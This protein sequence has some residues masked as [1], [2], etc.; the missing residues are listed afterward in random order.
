[1][2]VLCLHGMGS[3]C[4]KAAL[5][6]EL[7]D[8]YS[9]DFVDG[10]VLW[11]KDRDL[12]QYVMGDENT[13]AI[14]DPTKPDSCIQAIENLEQY[15]LTEGPYDGVMGF[16]QGA[17]IALSW[18]IKKQR[19]NK[20][21]KTQ[22]LPFKFGIFFSNP[23]GVYDA[24]ALADGQLVYLDPAAFEGLIDLPTAHIWGTGDKDRAMAQ[25]ISNACVAEK[26]SVFIHDQGHEIPLKKDAVISMAK[27]INRAMA[28]AQFV[29]LP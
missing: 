23:W 18:M 2:R 27:V 1:M 12:D 14:C 20:R 8:D 19:E 3:N 13:Y 17:N 29:E 16:S 25:M 15:I 11:E 28:Q 22:P 9:Y 26:R 24:N 4:R 6:Y 21:N 5:R 10:P 7:G